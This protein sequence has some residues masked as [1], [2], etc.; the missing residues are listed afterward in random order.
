MLKKGE[1]GSAAN[2]PVVFIMSGLKQLV[3][4]IVRDKGTLELKSYFSATAAGCYPSRKSN[5]LLS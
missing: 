3:A 2:A 4:T 5:F 1:A